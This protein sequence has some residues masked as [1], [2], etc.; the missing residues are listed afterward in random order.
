[1]QVLPVSLEIE[2]RVAD[3]LPRAM[4]RDVA[5]ALDLE[6]LH[7]LRREELGGRDQVRGLGGAPEGDHGRVLD[8][9]ED[10][11]VY[12][13]ADAPPR[14]VALELQRGPVGQGTEIDDQQLAHDRVR[15]ATARRGASCQA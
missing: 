15:P 3:Q 10:I 6:Q 12:L 13:A 8:E 11:L 7:A 14:D 1:M 2:N 9:E 4:E 5:A